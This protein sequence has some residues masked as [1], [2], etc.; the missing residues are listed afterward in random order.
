[1]SFDRQR[2]RRA[3][4]VVASGHSWK[5]A[6]SSPGLAMRKAETDGVETSEISHRPPI[7]AVAVSG[8]V[9]LYCA[10]KHAVGQPGGPSCGAC[11]PH[12]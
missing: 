7:S 5:P 1:M 4:D 2:S 3:L 12:P 10:I 9:P 11:Q 8:L 6:L